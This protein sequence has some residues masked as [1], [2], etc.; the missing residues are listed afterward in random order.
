MLGNLM[1]RFHFLD[2]YFLD[3]SQRSAKLANQVPILGILYDIG[4]DGAF[5]LPCVLFAHGSTLTRLVNILSVI[6]LVPHGFY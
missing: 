6:G 4:L 5:C 3:K 2:S 1:P